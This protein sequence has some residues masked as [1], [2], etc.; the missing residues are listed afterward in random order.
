MTKKELEIIKEAEFSMRVLL[1]NTSMNNEDL[2]I[3]NGIR[4]RLINLIEGR[5]KK[6]SGVCV[7]KE[8]TSIS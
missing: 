5:E 4:R 6:R 7:Y 2:G 1:E 3:A 8:T